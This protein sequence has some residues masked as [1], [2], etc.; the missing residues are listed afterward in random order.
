MTELNP[1]FTFDLGPGSVEVQAPW[2]F[3]GALVDAEKPASH[4]TTI[5]Q[6]I[7]KRVGEV[8][9]SGRQPG[10]VAAIDS[11]QESSSD[12][13]SASD[14]EGASDSDAPLPGEEDGSDGSEEEEGVADDSDDAEVNTDTE[15]DEGEGPSGEDAESQE[16]DEGAEG[17]RQPKG[18]ASDPPA[19]PSK[20]PAEEAGA[21]G[22][23]KRQVGPVPRGKAGGFYAA[24][25]EGTTFA[26]KTFAEL[27]LSKPLVKACQ[28]LGYTHPTPIQ[29]ACIPLALTGRDISGSAVTGSGKTAAFMLPLL[30]RLLHRSRRLAAMYVLVL[31]PVRELA[32]Q[33]H[34]M[35]QKLAQFT[36]I[37]A[38]LVVGGLS[39]QAQA[40]SLRTSPEIVVG[41]PGRVIDHVRNTQS[42]G[43]EDLQ[44]LILD[45]ADRLLEMGFADEIKEIVRLAP[46]KRQ[47]M[48]FS[49][50]MTEEV[51]KL[52]AVS[53]N[54]PVRLAADATAAAPKELTQEILRLKGA[55]ASQKEAVL[56]ALCSRTFASGRT[57]VFFSTKQRAHRMKILFGLGGLASAAELHGDMTQA[58][59]LQSLEAFRR[60]EA[61]FLLATDV[62]SRGLDIL[63]VETVINFDAP[64]QLPAYLHRVGRTARAGAL[65]RSVTFV[66][67]EDRALLKAV[68]KGTGV[69]LQQRQVPAVA[70]AAWQ[71]RVER[72]SDDVR[73]V[74]FEERDERHLRRAEMETQKA[75]NLIEHE[76]EIFSRPART[77]FQSEKEKRSAAEAARVAD[78]PLTGK[79]QKNRDKYQK[80][81]DMKARA[82]AEAAERKQGNRLME[83]TEGLSRTIRAIKSREKTLRM[84]GIGGAKTG[85]MAAGMVTGVKKKQGKKK[86]KDELFNGDGIDNNGPA[87]TG[88]TQ[89]YAGGARSS[90]AAVSWLRTG[91]PSNKL[92]K[93]ELARQKR[94]G[95][96]RHV[97][98]SK[99]KHRRR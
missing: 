40:A 76:S 77:W 74:I 57:I 8:R 50:T 78:T 18:T 90:K 84:T 46:R 83:E 21:A 13:D 16:S 39:L 69:Q 48:L 98:K 29:A 62:A 70:V 15:D 86:S 71:D 85:K 4:A 7:R 43:L 10:R 52:V 88:K 28:A 64:K 51:K 53:L 66:E 47:T 49:A 61:A 91:K 2:E 9:G 59:R 63:G 56:L 87:P 19:R 37:R 11:E 6:K 27:N 14:D 73:S 89:V 22:P 67:D 65:G 95:K 38:A 3:S 97:F 23:A 34:S 26:A 24:T 31:T 42:V 30:E 35:T 99:A 92:S 17:P 72:M 81:V 25:P 33:I 80:K 82:A 94:G 5:D 41:T 44:A 32:V 75:A 60:G 79:Q 68:V 55:E 1:G 54:R 45:E 58:A 12:S 96:G 36:D 20:R 93:A